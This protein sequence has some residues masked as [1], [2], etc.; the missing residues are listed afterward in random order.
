MKIEIIQPT[1][2]D[3]QKVKKLRLDALKKDP[4][5]FGASYEEEINEPDQY[6][7]EKL[8]ESIGKDSKEVFVV[9]KEQDEYVGML[10]SEE[11]NEGKW[12]IKAVYV[13]PEHRG[14][15]IANKLLENMLSALKSRNSIKEIELKVSAEQVAAVNLYK[16]Y[17]FEIM[18]TVDQELGD[19]KE[20]EVYLMKL[21][22]EI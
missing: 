9:A 18:D 3:W 17:G 16:K 8:E 13:K 21:K 2:Q 10:G 5:A 4:Q 7:Q 1:L 22:H 12:F 15:G 11:A 14:K 19:G 20:H 6:W